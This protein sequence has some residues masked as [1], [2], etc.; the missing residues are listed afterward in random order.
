MLGVLTA[1]FPVL[2]VHA[3]TPAADSDQQ[4]AGRALDIYAAPNRLVSLP[5]GRKMNIYCVGNGSP[6]IVLETGLDAGGT[7]DWRSVQGQIAKKTRT[8]SYDRA[9]YAFSDPVPS[10]EMFAMSRRTFTICLQAPGSAVPSCWW[11]I[12]W[13]ASMS[14]PLPGLTL[15]MSREWS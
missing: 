3:Q 7:L 4:T 8:C 12:P 5:D 15:V 13:A 1:F 11:V 9:G 14:G 2:A 6:T 10:Q